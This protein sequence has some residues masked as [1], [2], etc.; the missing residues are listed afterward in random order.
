[1]DYLHEFPDDRG[2]KG[3]TKRLGQ[4]IKDKFSKRG[5]DSTDFMVEGYDLDHDSGYILHWTYKERHQAEI[6]IT[7][8]E[9]KKDTIIINRFRGIAPLQPLTGRVSSS[10]PETLRNAAQIYEEIDNLLSKKFGKPV[11][12]LDGR[13][14]YL[15]KLE[16]KVISRQIA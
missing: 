8:S 12:E 15:A 16:E 11:S 2:I 3:F 4:E 13:S 6:M 9:N 5:W 10:S 1:M 7:E 14:I